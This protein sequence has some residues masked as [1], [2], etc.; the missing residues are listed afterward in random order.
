ML[1]GC[2]AA[3]GLRPRGCWVPGTALVGAAIRALLRRSPP[4]AL[5]GT[6]VDVEWPG[7]QVLLDDSATVRFDYLVPALGVMPGFAGVP[8][9]AGHAIPLKLVTDTTELRYKLL[10]V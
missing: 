9:A 2:G 8:G 7:Q 4:P 3:T 1:P 6:V 10:R 5:H